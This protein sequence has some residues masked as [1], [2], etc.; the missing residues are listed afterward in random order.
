MS[1]EIHF[2]ESKDD[3]DDWVIVQNVN[4]VSVRVADDYKGM[5]WVA[6]HV[7]DDECGQVIA[8]TQMCYLDT[9]WLEE[10]YRIFV[11]DHTGMFE[12]VLGEGNERTNR[13]I[14][15]A[16]SL[17]NLWRGGEFGLKEEE[18]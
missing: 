3:E 9:R 14:R 4:E 7:N 10:G 16:N 17:F 6:G 5:K 13:E 8:T 11:H 12:I 18:E 2:F 1:K 15:Y